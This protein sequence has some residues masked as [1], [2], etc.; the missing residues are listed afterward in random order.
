[1]FEGKI[2]E[3]QKQFG[4]SQFYHKDPKAFDAAQKNLEIFQKALARAEERWLELSENE[5]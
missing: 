2:Q 4:D 1:M 5:T 3:I